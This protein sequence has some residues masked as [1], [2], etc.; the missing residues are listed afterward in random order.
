MGGE[1]N[2]EPIKRWPVARAWE[3][4]VE[5][6]ALA[7]GVDPAAITA[8]TRGRGPRPPEAVREPKKIAVFVTIVLSGSDYTA[9]AR[10]LGMHKDT[11]SSHCASVREACC[12][13]VIE[14]QV[15]AIL[16]TSAMRLELAKL[17]PETHI[18]P[19]VA[20]DWEVALSRLAIL[21]DHMAQ[22]FATLRAALSD[23]APALIRRIHPTSPGSRQRE[24]MG[25]TTERAA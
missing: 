14:R 15:E 7:Y 6:T 3:V 8:E 4:A 23:E 2:S 20:S 13:D 16:A 11:I 25:G 9:L 1:L 12:A 19:A 18:L 17:P 21:E 5:I 24:R 22:T 10:H